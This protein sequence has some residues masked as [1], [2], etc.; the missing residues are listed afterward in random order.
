MPF[1]V[2]GKP[3]FKNKTKTKKNK[4]KNPWKKFPNPNKHVY[5]GWISLFK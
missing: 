5:K 3:H 4:Q 2:K 1:L